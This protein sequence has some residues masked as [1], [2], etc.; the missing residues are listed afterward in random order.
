VFALARSRCSLHHGMCLNCEMVQTTHIHEAKGTQC[1]TISVITSLRCL[2]A[3]WT[4][5]YQ[6]IFLWEIKTE[7]I[8]LQGS[9]R[10]PWK[11]ERC[12]PLSSPCCCELFQPF[13]ISNTR[14]GA[15]KNKSERAQT[16]ISLFADPIG[17]LGTSIS[18]F[19]DA[20]GEFGRYF[21]IRRCLRLIR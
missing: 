10:T 4:S 13:H 17:E 9:S 2:A 14:R 7:Y 21:L 11:Q 16:R 20:F 19:A 6:L 8:L 15:E 18:L 12:S 3:G 5:V 1:V